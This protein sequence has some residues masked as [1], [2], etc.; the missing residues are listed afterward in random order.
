MR[1]ERGRFKKEGLMGVCY[2]KMKRFS[3]LIYSWL[4]SGK[5]Y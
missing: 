2:E 5:L 1:A 4:I 3:S